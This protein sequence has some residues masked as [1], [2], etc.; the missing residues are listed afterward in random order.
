MTKG[1]KM[2]EREKSRATGGKRENEFEI[3][4]DEIE[5]KPS[6]FRYRAQPWYYRDFW[7]TEHCSS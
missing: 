2:L 7:N 1:A 5:N 6:I 4:E 3:E